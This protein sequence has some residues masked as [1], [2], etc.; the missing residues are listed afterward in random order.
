MFA[1]VVGKSIWDFTKFVLGMILTLV[2]AL[3]FVWGMS[4][5]HGKIVCQYQA[6]KLG[7]IYDYDYLAGCYFYFEKRW[8]PISHIDYCRVEIKKD[9]GR[10]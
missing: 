5:W 6:K 10:P 1:S 7:L 2:V 9:E 4:T 8:I 3:L